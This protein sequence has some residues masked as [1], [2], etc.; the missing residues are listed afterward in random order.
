MEIYAHRGLFDLYPE[1]SA[2]AILE[3]VDRGYGAEIDIRFSRDGEV[4]LIH[5]DSLRRLFGRDAKVKDLSASELSGLGFCARPSVRLALFRDL[6]RKLGGRRANLAIHFKQEEQNRDNCLKISS[7]FKEFGRYDDCFLFNLSLKACETFRQID[8]RIRLGVIVSDESF[9]PFVYIW[10]EIQE[11]IELFDIIWAAEYKFL[12]SGS[13]FC[14]I[15]D[16]GKKAVAVSH[17]LHRALG[18]PKAFEGYQDPWDAFLRN[19]V[20]VCTDY[21]RVFKEFADGFKGED[22]L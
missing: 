5:D 10:K 14:K 16:A 17:E 15:K 22:A 8:R 13:F 11:V 4:V 9:E 18:H 1:N 6:L 21:P 20:S 12:Y 3:S 7:L 2:E 19:R